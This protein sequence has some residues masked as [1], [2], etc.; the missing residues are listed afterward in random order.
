LI[1][2]KGID[3]GCSRSPID[4][5]WWLRDWVVLGVKNVG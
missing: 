5:N 4:E 3:G 1:G 2:P